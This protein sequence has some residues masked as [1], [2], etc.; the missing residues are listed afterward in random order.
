MVKDHSDS[1]RQR[2]EGNILF[3]NALNTFIYG[4]MALKDHSDS[5]RGNQL[6]SHRLLFPISSKSSFICIYPLFI[7]T[8]WITH[9]TAFVTPVV[10]IEIAQCVHH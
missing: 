2:K 4:Y 5:E 8:D 10:E 1:K 9:T 6:P 3:N 7:S